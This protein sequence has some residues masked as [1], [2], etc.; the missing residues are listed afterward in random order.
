MHKIVALWAVPRSTSTAFEWMMRQ[1]GDLDCLHEPFGEAWYQGEDPLWPRYREGE[2]TTPGLTLASVWDEI[3]ARAARGPVFLKDFPH[4]INH[5]WTPEFLGHFTHAFLIRD[6][7][8]TVTSMYDK[9]PDFDELEVGFPE[10]RALFDL[11]T[12]LNGAPPPVI[13]SGDLLENPHAITEAFCDAVGIPFLEHALTWEP[14]A[15]TGQYSWWDGGSFHQNLKASTG[16]T[17]Q[18][19]RYVELDDAPERVRQVVR[20]MRPHYDHLHAHRLKV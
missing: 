14:G 10:Q 15:D 18:K 3:R 2:K 5:M 16:L 8:L 13:D 17:P 11:L 1:R 20:R 7:A 6:P 9:W 4:Y 19:R 12:A